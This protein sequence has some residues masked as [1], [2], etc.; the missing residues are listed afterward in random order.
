VDDDPPAATEV[1]SGPETSY[2]RRLLLTVMLAV[3]G[4]G[5]L[6]TIVTVSL[7]VI[8]TDLDSSRTTLGWIVTGLMLTMAVLTPLGGKLGDIRG[9]RRMFLLGLAGSVVFT[10][11][12]A[13]AWNAAS[14]ITFRVL[15]GVAGALVQPN[16]MALMMAA[17]GPKRR[18]TAMGW[19][20]FATTGA[21]TIGLV[22]G[23]PMVDVIGW[24]G[25]FWVFAAVSVIAL[26]AAFVVLRESELAEPVPLDVVG[27]ITLAA[28]ILLAL[29][30]VSRGVAAGIADVPTL[31]MIGGSI[32]ALGLFI[33]TERTAPFPLL[34][35]TYFRRPS[36]TAPL[37]ANA[38]NQFAYMGGFVVTPLLLGDDIYGYG[39]GAVALAMAPRP[40][41]FAVASPLGG[42]VAT[43]IGE[44]LPMVTSSA[45]MVASM[46]SFAAGSRPGA[47]VFV[48]LGLVLSGTAAGIGAPS[49]TSLVVRSVDTRDVGVATGMNQ[50][51][52]FMGIVSGIQIMLVVLGDSPSQSRYA[53]TFVAGAV[54]AGGGLVASAIAAASVRRRAAT[55]IADGPEPVL[56]ARPAGPDT[57]RS[58]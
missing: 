45:M 12:A 27:S 28:T 46:L 32:V 49:Y 53:G 10:A 35:L 9:H 55:T 8:A 4:F 44:A 37:A 41:A 21:P 29:L 39:V 16:A 43:R 26:V 13:L 18:A 40:G 31:A 47:L 6:M 34:R 30:A 42:L 5:S 33:R 17:Y 11:L 14:L 22:V 7:S 56:V 20:Q 57:R 2:R 54:I 24:R 50:T 52:L 23:G 38:L 3:M 15:F 48:L 58:A 19:F 25:I 1:G 51:M 36:F